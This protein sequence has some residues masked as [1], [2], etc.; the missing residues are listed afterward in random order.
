M[1]MR[2]PGLSDGQVRKWRQEIVKVGLWAEPG[3]GGSVDAAEW[4]WGLCGR[5]LP[6]SALTSHPRPS[7]LPLRLVPAAAPDAG[8]SVVTSAGAGTF[9]LFITD[10][11]TGARG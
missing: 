11:I 8:R 3:G 10:G 4:E 5:A 9:Q 1:R 6:A 7:S 2:R